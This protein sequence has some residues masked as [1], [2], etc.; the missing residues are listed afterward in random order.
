MVYWPIARRLKFPNLV[1]KNRL[2]SA[3][4]FSDSDGPEI[5][6][7]ADSSGIVTVKLQIIAGFEG[8]E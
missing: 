3:G 4:P 1:V 5:A 6:Y 7:K 8:L 2:T